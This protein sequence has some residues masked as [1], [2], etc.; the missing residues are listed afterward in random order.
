MVPYSFRVSPLLKNSKAKTR[1][2]NKPFSFAK[3]L[4]LFFTCG[5]RV[6]LRV[7]GAHGK[8]GKGLPAWDLETTKYTKYTKKGL[9]VGELNHGVAMS[10]FWVRGSE[11]A[12]RRTACVD[13]PRVARSCSLLRTGTFPCF[14]SERLRIANVVVKIHHSLFIIHH[15]SLAHAIL[16]N[17]RAREGCFCDHE[18]EHFIAE[19]LCRSI[20]GPI[21]L[22]RLLSL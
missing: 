3:R 6:D 2:Q 8:Q 16:C 14:V 18:R 20:V 5:E 9:H 11:S 15:S 21:S 19:G 10:L 17:K 4:W 12:T 7:H 22:R 13:F 1:F